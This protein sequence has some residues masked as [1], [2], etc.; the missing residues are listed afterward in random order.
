MTQRWWRCKRWG[1]RW[2]RWGRRWMA[3]ERKGSSKF[4]AV[5]ADMVAG[6]AS[7]PQKGTLP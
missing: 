6:T 5:A 3:I 7:I 1:R 2:K 4:V